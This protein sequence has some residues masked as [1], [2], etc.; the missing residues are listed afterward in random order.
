MRTTN[1]SKQVWDKW[2]WADWRSDEAL[3]L[4]SFAARGLWME[5]LTLM[6]MSERKG[7][8]LV[9]GEPPSETDLI[10]LVRGSSRSEFRRLMAELKARGVYSVDPGG[11]IFSRRMVRTR[12]RSEINTANGMKGGN[13]KL[14]RE[15]NRPV[16]DSVDDSVNRTDNRG[17][18]PQKL[19]ARSYKPEDQNQDQKEQRAVRAIR[20][21]RLDEN[22]GLLT[23][24]A[25]HIY[26]DIERGRVHAADATEELKTRAARAHLRYDGDRVRKALES[27]D[28]QRRR[29]A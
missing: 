13:P 17:D 23:R 10:R 16:E 29:Q 22:Q 4:C 21:P 20:L 27:A 1:D 28:V 12:T 19:E 7:E 6:A 14:K 2:F 9:Q 3:A 11:T 8:L 25:H 18:K 24:I 15:Y 26:D 5:L